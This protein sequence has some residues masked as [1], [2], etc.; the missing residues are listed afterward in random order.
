MSFAARVFIRHSK[1][2]ASMRNPRVP[3]NYTFV[4]VPE[5][6]SPPA[7]PSI[8]LA[9]K[10]YALAVGVVA[11][12]AAAEVIIVPARNDARPTNRAPR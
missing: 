12:S 11:A 6:Y 7:T 3:S 8:A 5:V 2:A 4:N 10:S 9:F 1:R